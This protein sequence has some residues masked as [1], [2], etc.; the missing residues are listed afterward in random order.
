AYSY[1]RQ[2]EAG[3]RYIALSYSNVGAT[4]L[5]TTVEDL[6]LWDENFYTGKVGGK[7]LL[8]QMQ[9]KGKL[10]NGTEIGYAS[11]LVIGTYRGL[12]TVEHGGGD[13]GFRTELLRFPD[14]HFSSSLYVTRRKRT[15][16][17]WR[18]K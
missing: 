18:A 10:N 3:Y 11:A 9:I 1:R 14:Q 13:T 7:D 4:S 2:G 16:A 8:A 17:A 15:P 5:F 12:K 6:A